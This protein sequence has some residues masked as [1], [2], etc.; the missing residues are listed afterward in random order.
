MTALLGL[1][2]IGVLWVAPIFVAHEIGKSKNREGWIYGLGLGWLGVLVIAL[3]EPRR[4]VYAAALPR[5]EVAALP[6]RGVNG[7]LSTLVVR[8]A[9]VHVS[10]LIAESV[11]LLRNGDYRTCEPLKEAIESA[12]NE[13]NSGALW[14]IGQSAR[15]MAMSAPAYTGLKPEL[16]KVAQ[17]AEA[18]AGRLEHGVASSDTSELDPPPDNPAAE[19]RLTQ[20]E[21]GSTTRESTQDPDPVPTQSRNG[22]EVPPFLL[23]PLKKLLERYVSG[24]IDRQEF[25]QKRADLL[26]WPN[27]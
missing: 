7:N 22:T 23:D 5:Q 14:E 6:R 10:G 21:A 13:G 9:G 17:R 26:D 8:H 2:L 18:E 27:A 19:T 20:S 16:L 24:D 11:R 12:V 3:R 15:S 1:V 25:L 4:T